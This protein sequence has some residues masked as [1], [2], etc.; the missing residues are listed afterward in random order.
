MTKN[1]ITALVQDISR[2][3]AD[4]SSISAYYDEIIEELGK[5]EDPPIV[6]RGLEIFASGTSSYTY[7]TTAIEILYAFHA[8]Y[9]LTHITQET[10]EAYNK[11]WRSDSGIPKAWKTEKENARTFRLYPNP[12]VTSSS[13]A[14]GATEPF[15]EHFPANSGALIYSDSR[16]SSISDMIGL[17]VA[18]RVL[19]K[20]FV[21]PSDHQD[22]AWA[23]LHKQISDMFYYTGVM[24]HGKKIED[25][26]R[27]PGVPKATN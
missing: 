4:A 22:V 24:R 3:L 25:K 18:F 8:S 21:R 11:D 2:D 17:Y 6:E 1:E 26:T 20:E 23:M 9:H 10:L 5:R 7:P 27:E 14:V 13:L 12:N 16:E 15:G 19:Y